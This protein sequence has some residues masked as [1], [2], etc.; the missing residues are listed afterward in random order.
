MADT[1]VLIPHGGTEATGARHLRVDTGRLRLHPA[2][3]RALGPDARARGS[4]SRPPGRVE[5]TGKPGEAANL[6]ELPT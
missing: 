4:L 1:L 6:G 5:R 2:M 3:L